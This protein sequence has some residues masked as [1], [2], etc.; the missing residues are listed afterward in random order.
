MAAPRPRGLSGCLGEVPECRKA[1]GRRYPPGTVLTIAVAAR[2]AGY[3]GVTALARSAA[4]LSR[5]RPGTME[6][7][8]SPSRKRYTAPSSATLHRIL[9]DLPRNLS[10]LTD[11]AIAIVRR[12]GRF[13]HIP[14][15]SRHRS[16]RAREAPG[17]VLDPPGP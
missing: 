7:F 16:A 9:A 2:P 11:A 17:P 4:P 6:S 5:E 3:R 14:E 15:A 13:S 12:D 10:C 8:P 1:R